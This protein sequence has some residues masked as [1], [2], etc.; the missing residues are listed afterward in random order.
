LRHDPRL[1]LLDEPTAGIDVGAKAEIH[2][3][4]RRLAAAG[5]AIL[6]ASSD[7]LELLALADR[8]A[9]L[10]AGRLV[11]DMAVGEAN[12]EQLAALITGVGW[13]EAGAGKTDP[14]AGARNPPP[15]TR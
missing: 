9:C 10:Y 2:A 5:A 3:I 15:A 1:L 12:E 6:L 4:I 13:R 14:R 8:I 7:L 11:G